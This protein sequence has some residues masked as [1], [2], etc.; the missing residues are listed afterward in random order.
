MPVVPPSLRYRLY[1]QA[2]RGGLIDIKPASDVDADAH[3]LILGLLSRLPDFSLLDAKLVHHDRHY[4]YRYR[5]GSFRLIYQEDDGWLLLPDQGHE[6]VIDDIV[7]LFD[8]SGRCERLAEHVP[9]PPPAPSAA[10]APP[11]ASKVAAKRAGTSTA[12]RALLTASLLLFVVSL[13]LPP[14]RVEA[15]DPY[16]WPRGWLVLLMG[17]LGI[18]D[19]MLAWFANPLLLAAWLLAWRRRRGATIVTAALAL[20]LG[21]SFLLNSQISVDEAGNQSPL[22]HDGSGYWLWLGSLAAILLCGAALRPAADRS[23]S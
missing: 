12:S 1:R 6:R 4:A 3:E 23:T 10:S 15:A 19:G 8:A 5:H 16:P 13:W 2:D 18:A 11:A 14:F 22:H 17:W 7:L 21:L 20:L 9:V